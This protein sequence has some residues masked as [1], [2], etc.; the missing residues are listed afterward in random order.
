MAIQYTARTNFRNITSL[1]FIHMLFAFLAKGLLKSTFMLKK[2]YSIPPLLDHRVIQHKIN[3]HFFLKATINLRITT[4]YELIFAFVHYLMTGVLA[5]LTGDTNWA[6]ITYTT[7]NTFK[8]VLF[9]IF[10]QKLNERTLI[11]REF[12]C[13][14]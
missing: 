12:N 2:L 10:P 4:T 11:M 6:E 14:R 7:I 1:T 9:N 3:N 13:C 8:S 5:I